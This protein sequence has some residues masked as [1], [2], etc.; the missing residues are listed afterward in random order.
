L[1]DVTDPEPLPGRQLAL[2]TYDNYIALAR[3]RVA[4]DRIEPGPVAPPAGI[5]RCAYDDPA[6]GANHG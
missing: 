1:F 2:W 6:L 3:V 5:P 4:S